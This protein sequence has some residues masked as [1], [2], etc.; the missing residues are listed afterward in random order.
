[1]K[2]FLDDTFLLHT[3]TAELLYNEFAKDMPIID[4]HNHLPPAQIAN[5]INFQNLTQAWLYGDHYKW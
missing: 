2:T 4:Y 1:M 3:K 5:N